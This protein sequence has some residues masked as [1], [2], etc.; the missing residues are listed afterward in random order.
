MIRYNTGEVVGTTIDFAIELEITR[1][2][3]TGIRLAFEFE[4]FYY[5]AAAKR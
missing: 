5:I 2:I 3:V 4:Y 1:T